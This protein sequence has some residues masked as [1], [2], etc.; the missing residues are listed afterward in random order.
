MPA[1][2]PSASGSKPVRRPVVHNN[3][4]NKNIIIVIGE[5]TGDVEKSG[6]LEPRNK[7]GSDG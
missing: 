1:P 4:N 3:N 2:R 6:G 7:D 5:E